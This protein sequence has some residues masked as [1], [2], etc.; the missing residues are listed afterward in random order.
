MEV[1]HPVQY[2]IRS[3]HTREHTA[4]RL[5]RHTPT[6]TPSVLQRSASVRRR[7]SQHQGPK[8]NESNDESQIPAAVSEIEELGVI[9]PLPRSR[10]PRSAD[11]HSA[12][13]R[14]SLQGPVH[15]EDRKLSSDPSLSEEAAVDAQL[16]NLNLGQPSGDSSTLHTPND[17]VQRTSD[18]LDLTHAAANQ[19]VIPSR[20][21]SENDDR[22]RSARLP[23][24]IPDSPATQG[25]AEYSEDALKAALEG[26]NSSIDVELEQLIVGD[27]NLDVHV[28][29]LYS[30]G[31]HM[32][33]T[34]TKVVQR[35]SSLPCTTGVFSKLKDKFR[36][37]PERCI[38]ASHAQD[39]QEKCEESTHTP[40]ALNGV[41]I[42]YSSKDNRVI[43]DPA[44]GDPMQLTNS[45]KIR[46]SYSFQARIGLFRTQSARSLDSIRTFTINQLQPLLR[47]LPFAHLMRSTSFESASFSQSVKEHL[48]KAAF[49]RSAKLKLWFRAGQVS[50][51][52]RSTVMRVA[53]PSLKCS[54]C[55]RIFKGPDRKR[56][57]ARHCNK[58]H[59]PSFPANVEDAGSVNHSSHMRVL[60]RTR[61]VLSVDEFFSDHSVDAEL[62]ESPMYLDTEHIETRRSIATSMD[63]IT[64]ADKANDASLS[65]DLEEDK[66][67]WLKPYDPWTQDDI[68][69]TSRAAFADSISCPYCDVEYCGLQ[70]KV[71]LNRHVNARHPEHVPKPVKRKKIE[72]DFI[73]H[74]K[75]HGFRNKIHEGLR[76]KEDI[77][78]PLLSIRH[79]K[80]KERQKRLWAERQRKSGS[81]IL[82]PTGGF[83]E[84]HEYAQ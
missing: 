43:V 59:D 42:F 74:T 10:T 14:A 45:Q 11:T 60:I 66:V 80:A 57:Y 6:K 9:E 48:M 18:V 56:R 27:A 76:L 84:L 24:P 50:A 26:T 68:N 70:K 22:R 33:N 17:H 67:L 63:L 69:H 71:Y 16:R 72:N 5:L 58:V 62:P 64:N 28:K 61:G 47:N 54:L 51:S 65:W 2:P 46:R 82:A 77:I 35:S 19:R 44:S 81:A 53:Y 78:G 38:S 79:D 34:D 40:R 52:G 36:G 41:S 37:I 29:S 49:S 7:P 55:P 21:T 4:D 15:H 73:Q 32:L 31:E 23:W 1:S 12:M 30:E 20:S 3:P 39:S 75:H 25:S 8:R 83:I 13:N